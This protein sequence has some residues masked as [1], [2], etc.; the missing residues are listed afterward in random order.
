MP[1]IIINAT[2]TCPSCG[3]Q[4]EEAMPENA[5]VHFWE[6]PQCHVVVTPEPG[7]CCVFCSHSSP[8]C[9]PRQREAGTAQQPLES[10]GARQSGE[11]CICDRQPCAQQLNREPLGSA[12]TYLDN[13]SYH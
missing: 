2:I 6:C 10:G 7:K 8:E 13:R 4:K 11:N 9:P 5:C 12:K 1:T 3:Y